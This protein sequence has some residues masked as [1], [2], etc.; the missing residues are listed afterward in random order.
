LARE[1]VDRYLAARTGDGPDLF[2]SYSPDDPNAGSVSAAAKPWLRAP[3]HPQPRHHH[4]FR[5]T[6]GN[7]VQDELGDPRLTADYLGHHGQGSVAG[8]TE[9]S[10]ARRAEAGEALHRRGMLGR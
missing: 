6:T 7:I 3:R 10:R 5:Q 4:R 8:Y 2:V 9:L 1:E